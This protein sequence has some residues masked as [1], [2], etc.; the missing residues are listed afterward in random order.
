[1]FLFEKI[2][3]LWRSPCYKKIGKLVKHYVENVNRENVE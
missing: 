1:M 3:V 2:F